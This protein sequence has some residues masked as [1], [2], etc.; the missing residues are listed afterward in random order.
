[1]PREL[2]RVVLRARLLLRQQRSPRVAAGLWRVEATR[3]VPLGAP[4]RVARSC[5]QLR[6]APAFISLLITVHA[7]Q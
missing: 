5:P 4:V 3:G 1:M 7:Y 6:A 2:E